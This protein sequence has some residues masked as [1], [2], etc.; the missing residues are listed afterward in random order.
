FCLARK[1]EENSMKCFLRILFI[2]A[3]PFFFSTAFALPHLAPVH[4]QGQKWEYLVEHPTDIH[5]I[6]PVRMEEVLT[7][8]GQHGWRLVAVTSAFHFYGFYFERPLHNHRLSIVRARLLASKLAREKKEAKLYEAIR[9][10]HQE[11]MNVQSLT[12]Q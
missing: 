11:K 5:H 7:T 6:D 9:K 12:S 2:V 4:W 10:A 8:A 3:I 1:Y